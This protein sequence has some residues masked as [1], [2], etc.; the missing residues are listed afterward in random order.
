MKLELVRTLSGCIHTKSDMKAGRVVWRLCCRWS[1]LELSWAKLE[2]LNLFF[3]PA[4]ALVLNAALNGAMK[5]YQT[6]QNRGCQVLP[7]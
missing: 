5:V 4:L 6:L 1:E 7:N 2:A 3:V